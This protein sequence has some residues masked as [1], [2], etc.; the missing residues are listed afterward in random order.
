MKEKHMKNRIGEENVFFY[1]MYLRCNKK[2]KLFNLMSS[3]MSL[4]MFCEACQLV[5]VHSRLLLYLL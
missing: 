2:K 4:L 3:H 5:L 1:C